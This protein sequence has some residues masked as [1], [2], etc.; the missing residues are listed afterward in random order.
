MQ[1]ALYRRPGA[2]PL[3]VTPEE[4]RALRAAAPFVGAPYKKHGSTPDGW[5]CWGCARYLA[6]EAFGVDVPGWGEVYSA[7]DV[8]RPDE[9]ERLILEHLSAWEEVEVRPGA[10]LLFEVFGRRAHVGLMLT[11]RDFV[12]TLAGQ[13]TTIVTL[14]GSTWQNRLR[15][16]YE[17][18][19]N[20]HRTGALHPAR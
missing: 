7:L 15:G 19:R 14:A 18:A 9:V 1:G 6:R 12:H 11:R 2:G 13:E 16:A 10:F 3:R 8:K 4:R 17:L 5:D 20:H